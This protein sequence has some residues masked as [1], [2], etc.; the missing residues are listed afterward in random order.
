M[1]KPAIK[2]IRTHYTKIVSSIAYYPAIIAVCFL[3]LSWLMLKLDFS[4]AGKSFKQQLT[5]LSLKDASTARS[6]LSTIA[7][8]VISL[9]VFSFS[10]VMI[11]LN[12]AASQMSNRIL[13]SMIEN[14]FQQIVLGF[15]IGTIVYALFLLST[16]RNIS[17]GIHVPAISIYL[18]IAITVADIFLFIYFLDYVTQTVKYETVIKRVKDQTMLAMKSEY[19]PIREQVP[20]HPG[21][22]YKIIKAAQSGYFQG[23]DKK[24]ILQLASK[25][26]LQFHFLQPF[27]T[28]LIEGADLAHVYLTPEI[29]EAVLE[30]F[31]VSVDFYDGQPIA[32]NPVYGFRQLA[33]VAI[34]ALSPGINDPATAVL[35]INA[36]AELFTYRMNHAQPLS[37]NTPEGKTGIQFNVPTFVALFED[38]VHPILDYGKEDRY[39]LQALSQMLN[40]LNKLD[41]E[42]KHTALFRKFLSQLQERTPAS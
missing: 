5:W 20:R 11:V 24:R 35:S 30:Q 33:E 12:Q 36:L 26:E 14:R 28:F 21:T 40:Q 19:C 41:Q 7:G 8:G 17:S 1:L 27:G 29:P 25:Y 18:L 42:H 34:K 6:V 2:W 39:V 4:E 38:C 3:I 9:T 10:M 13:N 22:A 37:L 16:I 32:R 23:V 15:Y 31:R